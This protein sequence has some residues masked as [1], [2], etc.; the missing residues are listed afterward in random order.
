MPATTTYARLKAY[1][2]RTAADDGATSFDDEKIRA[3]L[4]DA[5]LRVESVRDWSFLRRTQRI[6][7]TRPYLSTD[8]STSVDYTNGSTTITGNLTSFSTNGVVEGDYIEVNGEQ[9]WYEVASVGSETS[10]TLRSA[11]RGTSGSAKSFI[12]A[13]PWISLPNDFK[14]LRKLVP[15]GDVA[16]LQY[17]TPEDFLD[18]QQNYAGVSQPYHWTHMQKYDDDGEYLMLYPSPDAVYQY[19]LRYNR[20]IGFL[21][22]NTNNDWIDV[23]T[24]EPADDDIVLWDDRDMSVLRKAIIA[25]AYE[26]YEN[27]TL[28]DMAQQ[29]FEMSL[30]KAMMRDGKNNEPFVWGGAHPKR[31]HW[32]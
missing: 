17:T 8:D 11:Y 28:A 5:F 25:A 10:L 18:L 22:V 24:T 23:T 6:S 3:I 32:Y 21:D 20:R 7:T 12:I 26:E 19:E 2:R 13:R 15:L 1:I 27:P 16:Y 14:S 29:R 9:T 30:S 4:P 31:P